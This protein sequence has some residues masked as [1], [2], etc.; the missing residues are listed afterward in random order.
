[1]EFHHFKLARTTKNY[2]FVAALFAV[3]LPKPGVSAEPTKTI[4]GANS[5]RVLPPGK[6]P[7]D[8]RLGPLKD[9]NGYFPFTSPKSPEEWKTRAEQ[10]RQQILVAN[11]LW[12]MPERT[13]LNPVIHGKVEREGF[14][15]ERVFFESY[16]GHFVT[17]SLFRPTGRTGKLP[18]VLCPYG[19]WANGRF[20]SNSVKNVR[21]EIA[22]GAE[23]FEVG[24]RY[25]LQARCMQLARMGCVVF[26]YDMISVA[27]SQQLP[28]VAH[29]PGPRPQ[30]DTPK[31]W[32]FYSTQAELRLQ[33][34]MGLQTYNSLRALDFLCELPDVDAKRIGVTG[35]SG[36]GTQTF[37]LC[38]IDDRPAVAVPAVMVS[39]GMQ[40]GC[41]CENCSLLRLGTGNVEF[42]AMF[43]PKPLCLIG[44]NDWTVE[45]ATKGGPEL[46]QLYSLLGAKNKLQISPHNQ[47]G[48]NYNYVSRE[49]MYQW[50]NRHLGLDQESPVIEEDFKPLSIAELTVWDEKHPRPPSGE[51]YERSL[52]RQMTENSQ[53]QLGRLVPRDK[54]SLAEFQ[55]V[56]GVAW[57]T[58]LGSPQRL[59]S[60][61]E[62]LQVG[63][64]ADRDGYREIKG[65]LRYKLQREELPIVVLQPKQQ[66]RGTVIWLDP[67]GKAGLFASDKPRASVAKLLAG[68]QQVVGVDLLDQGEF[69]ADGKPLKKARLVPG[70]ENKFIAAFT[71]GYNP[72]V[73]AQRVQDVTTIISYFNEP[74]AILG[75][76]QS[77][78]QLCLA[79]LN[80]AGHWAAAASAL[81]GDAIDRTAIDTNGFR[82]ANVSG[83]DD[84]NFLPG[85]VKYFDLSG[86]LSLCAPGKFWLRD[87]VGDRTGSDDANLTATT[88]KAANATGNLVSFSGTK[89]EGDE[90]AVKWLLQKD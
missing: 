84:P 60:D 16:P 56:V 78:N 81:A 19:H 58:M 33:S 44:A 27:D 36:G 53:K 86:V 76:Q 80:G 55:Q 28:N 49:V 40:G 87:A 11:G 9:L 41:T 14:T 67:A 88:Y 21:Q 23:R 66:V 71:F 62:F 2:L 12:P 57:K 42:A 30:L 47:F 83:I 34:I 72:T 69:L 18:G 25:P 54:K 31:D 3:I 32:G 48:H 5:L 24:G 79:G 22:H 38:A 26:H 43:A 64:A 39:T 75:G 1:M 85:A 52:L 17:G 4:G 74:D 50:M 46:K 29:H 51:D 35:A 10:V 59:R 63:E 82:F 15:V 37:I 89:E 68:G 61:I 8:S 73:F 65:L 13:P 70:E 77:N 7:N 45:I 6:L 90:A 20:Y